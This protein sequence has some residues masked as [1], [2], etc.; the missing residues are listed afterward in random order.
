MPDVIT[1]DGLLGYWKDKF[2]QG[3]LKTRCNM[4]GIAIALMPIS[5]ILIILYGAYCCCHCL[6][7]PCEYV[8]EKMPNSIW[9]MVERFSQRYAPH[10][11]SDDV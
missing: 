11:P 4:I 6:C 8:A 3:T 1:L 9:D 5:I 2:I 7:I 10:Y